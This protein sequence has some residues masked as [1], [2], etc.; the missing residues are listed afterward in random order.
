MVY[1]KSEI[2]KDF[3]KKLADKIFKIVSNEYFL[4][5][6]ILI[7]A[8]FVRL[9]KI[10]NPIADWHS[11]RQADTA[12]VTRVYLEEGVNVLVPRYHDLSGIQS[13]W[14]NTH[15]YRFVEF[16]FFNLAHL[17][18]YKAYPVLNLEIWGRLTAVIFTLFSTTLVFLLGKRFISKWGGLLAAFFF[19]FI[20]YNIYFT[21]V[22]LPDPLAVT[23]ALLG[24]WLFT[25]FIDNERNIFLYSSA[26]VFAMSL[27]VKPFTIF[28][29]VPA[30]YLAVN[31]YSLAYKISYISTAGGAL[32]EYIEGKELPAL[33]AITEDI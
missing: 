28:Y 2:K 30:I 6:I 9:Y 12:S 13:G 4:L 18:L 15:G 27:M 26:L 14:M 23:L 22:I 21:R 29:L 5:F 11:W 7:G 20:P 16:P 1:H 33:K 8:F 25:K 24:L 31:K 32:L 10:D 17:T 19:A 3:M